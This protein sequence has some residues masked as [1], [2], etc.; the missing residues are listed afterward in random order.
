MA[1]CPAAS[2]AN[3]VIAAT[4]PGGMAS[5]S[6]RQVVR[7]CMTCETQELPDKGGGSEGNEEAEEEIEEAIAPLPPPHTRVG[8][9]V[10]TV[11]L[12][13]RLLPPLAAPRE[14]D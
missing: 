10:L 4:P 2:R 11:V 1:S 12:E 14:V 8:K 5:G 13:T 7:A 9:V 3:G 6:V